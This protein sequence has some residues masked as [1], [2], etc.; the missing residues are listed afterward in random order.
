[1]PITAMLTSTR[2]L[3]TNNTAPAPRW[4]FLFS[5][6]SVFD[7]V[8]ECGL[9]LTQPYI[10]FVSDMLCAHAHGSTGA[11]DVISTRVRDGGDEDDDDSI[12]GSGACVHASTRIA[13]P[14]EGSAAALEYA[15]SSVL[16]G[17]PLP[18]GMRRG[19]FQSPPPALAGHCV[20]VAT[21]GDDAEAIAQHPD[22]Y[23]AQ[24]QRGVI[25]AASNNNP[26][27]RS[28][29]IPLLI[30]PRCIRAETVARSG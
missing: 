24:S 28:V 9:P 21:W 29:D 25:H 8:D 27:A 5:S 2:S 3:L 7:V 10:S 1:M 15:G 12:S 14:V 20:R 16:R 6:L 19:L 11:A 30:T 22:R 4:Q 17:A 23:Q 13:E 26:A 18:H